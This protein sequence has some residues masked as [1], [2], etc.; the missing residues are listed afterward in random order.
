MANDYLLAPLTKLYQSSSNF[1]TQMVVPILAI[2]LAIWLYSIAI[3]LVE[4]DVSWVCFFGN[5]HRTII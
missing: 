1:P 3:G 5:I 2:L 4:I